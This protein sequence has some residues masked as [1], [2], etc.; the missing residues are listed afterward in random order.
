[1]KNRRPKHLGTPRAKLQYFN[2]KGCV[3]SSKIIF[4][5][6]YINEVMAA[7]AKRGARYSRRR[8]AKLAKKAAW[9]DT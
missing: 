5:D 1:M 6:P 4:D 7:L 2:L 8:A 9:H 3:E